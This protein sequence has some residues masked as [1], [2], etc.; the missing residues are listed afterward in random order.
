[1]TQVI[2][3]PLWDTAPDRVKQNIFKNAI[4]DARALGRLKALP[5]EQ[6]IEKAQAIAARLADD[7]RPK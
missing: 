2:N 4:K 1:M 3:S 6:R 7:L 5:I